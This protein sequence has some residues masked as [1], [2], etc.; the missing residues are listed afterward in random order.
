VAPRSKCD[1]RR[2][3][4]EIWRPRRRPAGFRLAKKSSA[5]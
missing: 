5:T 4:G 1:Q 2:A 3:R